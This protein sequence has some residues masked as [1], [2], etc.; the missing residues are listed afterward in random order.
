M[1][2][3]NG[4]IV[5]PDTVFC[6][7]NSDTEKYTIKF[8]NGKIYSY[9][10]SNVV[11]IRDPEI[12]NPGN[13][14]IAHNGKELYG[15]TVI[16]KFQKENLHYWHICFQ[17]GLERDY[18]RNV[19]AVS[20]SCL[21]DED[22]KSIFNYLKRTAAFTGIR[23][24][25]GTNLLEQQYNKMDYVSKDTVFSTYIHPSKYPVKKYN[26][27]IPIFPFGC[28]ASQFKA[29]KNA[30]ENQ[31]SVIQGPPGTGKTQT[32]L[33]IIANLLVSGKTVQVVSNNNSATANIYEKLSSPKYSLD[34]LV[35]PLGNSD[36]K[37]HFL[38]KQSGKYPENI[39]SWNSK[40]SED[41]DFS[42]EALRSSEKLN[43]IFQKQE[44]LSQLLQ[45]LDE[46]KTESVHFKQYATETVQGS[47]DYHIHR[48]TGSE[49]ILNLLLQFQEFSI[50]GRKPSLLFKFKAC[51]VYGIGNFDF[52]AQD[53]SVVTTFFQTLFYKKKEDELGTEIN[54]LNKYLSEYNCE[55]L[56]SRQTEAA[57][58][59][60]KQKLYEKYGNRKE[61]VIFSSEDLWQNT[62]EVQKEYPV[63]LST[64]FS[65]RS[66][67]STK[68]MF[69][70]VLIDEASQVDIATGALALSCAKN[71][72]IV[73]D[74]KQLPNVITE[75]D[76]NVLQ[77]IFTSCN[78]SENYNF[79]SKSFLQSVC[80]VLQDIPVTLLRE[81]YRCHPK[82][83]NFFNQK[84]YDGNL[85][86]MTRDDNE[87]DV[88]SVIKTPV[89][90]HKRGHVNQR[91]ID[92]ITKEVLP[93]LSCTD[94]ETGIIAPYN[95]QVNALQNAFCDRQINIATVHKFQG[96]EKNSI[97]ISTVDDVITSFSDDPNL[98]NVAV[99][100]AKKKLRLVVSGNEQPKNSNISDL[101]HYIEYNNFTVKDSNVYSVF[102]FLYRQYT[103]A[104]HSF[105]KSYKTVSIY[106]S[107]NLMYALIMEVLRENNFSTFDVL[108]HQSL[109][110][111]IRDYSK[112]SEDEE[113]YV[114]NP[115]THLDFLIFNR[116]SKKPILAIEVDGFHFHKKGTNQ[117]FR[118]MMK[119]HILEIYGLP[120]L[121]FA[122]NGSEEKEKL[123]TKLTELTM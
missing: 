54:M 112:L 76:R 117:S 10:A 37:A 86:I 78:I 8:T 121:R 43:T 103:E 5:T 118:D 94:E 24:D 69:D 21:A 108:C 41:S 59:Y 120:L 15:I 91:Q 55:E 2:I 48:K 102:D 93:Y 114:K 107:E 32:I 61:R 99:S 82:I 26:T 72:V 46:L 28:N 36:N 42:N 3:A 1:I 79:A 68:A 60:L 63:V 74:A 13:Y 4:K 19:L 17:N 23:A 47:F 123:H 45:I 73:G 16:F 115:A 113:R 49:K 56:L 97:I 89:G 20:V 96:R 12:L 87:K 111:L 51:Y 27:S 70:Y 38:E 57:M 9:H 29:V 65:A 110:M 95:E 85:L 83:A 6:K 35:A 106:D 66:S 44:R 116:I 98:L 109:N 122:T 92:V 50:K 88:I 64:T 71:T 25:D 105:L 90:N 58:L 40:I 101:I 34:F 52:Y 22:T 75:N 33:N 119:N 18:D 62:A 81:H 77:S 30:L 80:D 39:S 31:F 84:F 7:Y 53:P 104:R 67:L 14:Q 11:W 100:R